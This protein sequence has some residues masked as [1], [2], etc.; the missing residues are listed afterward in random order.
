MLRLATVFL[1]AVLLLISPRADASQ[2]IN[3]RHLELGD[4]FD[5]EYAS[6][7]QI[8]PTGHRVVYVRNFFDIMTDRRQSNLWIVSFDGTDHRP[9]TSGKHRNSSPRWSP[10]ETKIAYISN[11]G[12]KSQS[13]SLSR[14]SSRTSAHPM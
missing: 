14:C 10:D 3:D 6:D 11:R 1:T 13:R 4:V 5:L 2:E 12:G 9:L 7:P 8:S